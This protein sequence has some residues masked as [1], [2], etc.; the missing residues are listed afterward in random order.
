[1]HHWLKRVWTPRRL[2]HYH[3]TRIVIR[4]LCVRIWHYTLHPYAIVFY[5]L[6]SAFNARK[7]TFDYNKLTGYLSDACSHMRRPGPGFGGTKV[8]RI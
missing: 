2:N 5:H 7:T 6:A 4:L 1:M 8:S 3:I